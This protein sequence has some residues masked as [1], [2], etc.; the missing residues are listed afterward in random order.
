LLNY[1]TE[2][3]IQV[4]VTQRESRL[5]AQR[6]L[7]QMDHQSI[8]KN[9]VKEKPPAKVIPAQF[10]NPDPADASAVITYINDYLTANP[11]KLADAINIELRT[12]LAAS[13]QKEKEDAKTGEEMAQDLQ[14]QRNSALIPGGSSEEF[15]ARNQRYQ[16]RHANT[17]HRHGTS[18]ASRKAQVEEAKTVATEQFYEN[19]YDL[20]VSEDDDDHSSDDVIVHTP[21]KRERTEEL[22][23]PSPKTPREDVVTLQFSSPSVIAFSIPTALKNDAEFAFSNPLKKNDTPFI[24]DLVA[25]WEKVKCELEAYA[26]KIGSMVEMAKSN[27]MKH[28]Q[29]IDAR[30]KKRS[31]EKVKEESDNR[32]KAQQLCDELFII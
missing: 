2:E 14:E 24:D 31:E 12:K 9:G 30:I 26:V 15:K 32:E 7:Q 5:I 21:H 29:T 18:R 28:L 6:L 10:T 16:E 17:Y 23:A 3:E 27:K 20:N 4:Y 11:K 22:P 1:L 13:K 19:A 8:R 25:G